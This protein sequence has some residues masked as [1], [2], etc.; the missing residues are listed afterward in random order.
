MIKEQFE[1]LM[2]LIEE[3]TEQKQVNLEPILM[4]A[5]Q[6]FEELRKAYAEA[7]DQDRKEITEMMQS[8][9]QKLQSVTKVVAEK[10][11]MS[12]EE[13]Y[14]YSENPSY[15]S[16]EQWRMVQDTKKKLF[17]SVRQFSGQ[18]EREKSKKSQR[19]QAKIDKPKPPKKTKKSGWL[20]T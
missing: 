12:E 3:S 1:K 8:L 14:T 18:I 9:Y 2:Q 16:P 19:S 20:K 11:G 5:V 13:L 10:A 7:N 17:E 6:F 15:F 4:Q